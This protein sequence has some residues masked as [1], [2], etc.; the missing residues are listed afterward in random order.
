MKTLIGYVISWLLSNATFKL[1]TS[2]DPVGRRLGGHDLPGIPDA[3]IILDIRLHDCIVFLGY[4][5]TA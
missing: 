5:Q 4:F 1:W 3:Y 2:P